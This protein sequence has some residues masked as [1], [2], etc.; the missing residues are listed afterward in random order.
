MEWEASLSGKENAN[1]TLMQ[2]RALLTWSRLT[3]KPCSPPLSHPASL[4]TERAG[5]DLTGGSVV[6]GNSGQA[7]GELL[8]KG[9]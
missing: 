1:L 2:H 7:G 5:L 3:E 8:D 6:P 4:S 9:V